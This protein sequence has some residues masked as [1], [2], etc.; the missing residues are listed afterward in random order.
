[1]YSVAAAVCSTASAALFSLVKPPVRD[2]QSH[3][4]TA[5]LGA[6]PKGGGLPPRRGLRGGTGTW[7]VK[8]L[9]RVEGSVVPDPSSAARTSSKVEELC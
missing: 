5:V 2:I 7:N 3:L 1:M 9:P 8:L 4:R 6:T